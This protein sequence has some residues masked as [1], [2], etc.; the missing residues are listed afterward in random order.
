MLRPLAFTAALLA[1]AVAQVG[2]AVAQADKERMDTVLSVIGKRC[3][4]SMMD[5]ILRSQDALFRDSDAS[6]TVATISDAQALVRLTDQCL[7]SL[8]PGS[9][10]QFYIEGIKLFSQHT[11]ASKFGDENSRKITATMNAYLTAAD[12]CRNPHVRDQTF[13]YKESR[14]TIITS[15]A[16]LH[17][18]YA[19]MNTQG[20]TDPAAEGCLAGSM[21]TASP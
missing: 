8:Q 4:W 7:E 12:L 19:K 2:S 11:I 14:M 5:T 20:P 21:P 1:F 6:D 16:S 15:V 10:A 17:L 3:G 18:L 9:A 13:P